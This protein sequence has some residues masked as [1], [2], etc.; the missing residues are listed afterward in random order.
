METE[1]YKLIY[2]LEDRHWWYRG[3]YDLLLSTIKRYFKEKKSIKVLD[4]GCGTGMLLK[5]LQENTI[6]VGID[7]SETA[8]EYCKKRGLEN[9]FL[10]ST[11]QLPFRNEV[12]DLI[13]SNGVLYHRGV[14]YDNEAIREFY[15]TM[16]KGALLI[17]D[18]PAFEHLRR[19]HDQ[20]VHTR[21]RY[22]RKELQLLLKKNNFSIIKISYRNVFIYPLILI[23]KLPF[24]YN[25]QRFD[26]GLNRVP[27][28]INLIFYAILRLEAL[29]LRK[30]NFPI[31]S[32]VFVLAVK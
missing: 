4:A 7:I 32:T 25:S 6:S 18:V 3:L 21:H 24:F 29:L 13:I 27:R 26:T 20:K 10:G 22:T 31:G 14:A 17:I 1:Q 9:A 5:Y 28:I 8:I 30:I 15:R 12:F 11:S 16:K 2:E 19:N 23:Q